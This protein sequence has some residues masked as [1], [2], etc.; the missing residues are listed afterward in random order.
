M[1][2]MLDFENEVQ[3]REGRLVWTWEKQV[4]EVYL[5]IE[6]R[7]EDVLCRSISRSLKV[8]YVEPLGSMQHLMGSVGM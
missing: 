8:V 7:M 5:R 3:R 1:R 6:L 4:E 2:M